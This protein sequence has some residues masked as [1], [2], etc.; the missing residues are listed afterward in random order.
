[1]DR[2]AWQATVH[3]VAIVRH[4]LATKEREREDTVNQLHSSFL[5]SKQSFQMGKEKLPH[6]SYTFYNV[7]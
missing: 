6:F 7:N 3:G 1:M 5:C 4:N 2:G